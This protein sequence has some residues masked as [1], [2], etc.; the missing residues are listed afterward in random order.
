MRCRGDGRIAM[1]VEKDRLITEGLALQ[2]AVEI[3][4]T[5][6]GFSHFCQKIARMAAVPALAVFG[7]MVIQWLQEMV[8]VAMVLGR[9]RPE[10]SEPNAN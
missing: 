4:A 3:T 8:T 5:I 9:E 1:G 6:V 7:G 2:V 10:S